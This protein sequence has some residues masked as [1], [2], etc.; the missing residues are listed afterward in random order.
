[1]PSKEEIINPNVRSH[2]FMYMMIEKDV[3]PR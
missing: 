2:L 3:T 1:M